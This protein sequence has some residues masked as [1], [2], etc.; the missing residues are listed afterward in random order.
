MSEVFPDAR[1]QGEGRGKGSKE[2]LRGGTDVVPTWT[3]E[4]RGEGERG[5][6]TRMKEEGKGIRGKYGKGMSVMDERVRERGRKGERKGSKDEKDMKG[7]GK[8]DGE[9]TLTP[10]SPPTEKHVT[11]P[12][13]VRVRSNREKEMGPK[14]KKKA[15][16]KAGEI[17]MSA[18]DNPDLGTF[19]GVKV[20][21]IRAKKKAAE[22]GYLRINLSSPPKGLFWGEFNDRRLDTRAVNRLLTRFRGNLDNCSENSAMDLAVRQEWLRPGVEFKATADGVAIADMTEIEFTD[23]GAMAMKKDELWMLGGNHRRKALSLYMAEKAKELEGVK[24]ALATQEEVEEGGGGTTETEAEIK[25]LRTRM[26][27]LEGEIEKGTFWVVRVYDRDAIEKHG[28]LMAKIIFRYLSRNEVKENY[29][30]T[31][32][33]LL[34]EI[35]VELRDAYE[36]DMATAAEK[37]KNAVA[38]ALLRKEEPQ[39]PEPRSEELAIKY[40][41]FVEAVTLKAK[42]EEVKDSRGYRRLC[43]VPSFAHGLVMA[44]RLRRHYTHAEWFRVGALGTMLEAHGGILSDFL[45]ES[46][47]VLER[48]ANP[49]KPPLSMA[50]IDTISDSLREPLGDIDKA[51]ENLEGMKKAFDGRGDPRKWTPELLNEID[52][53]F[54]N[55]YYDNG[56]VCNSLFI[57][58]NEDNICRF[59]RYCSDVD[60]VLTDN[61][62]TA[63]P[64]AREYFAYA[65]IWKVHGRAFPIP[66]G[67]ASVILA[68]HQLL[69][70]HELG[71]TETCYT[72]RTCGVHVHHM[73]TTYGTCPIRGA[74]AVLTLYTW[75][76]QPCTTYRTCPIR[77]ACAVLLYTTCPI[78]GAR[79]VLTLYTWVEQ[80]CTTYRTC[81]IRGARAVLLYTW[82]MSYTWCMCGADT[83]ISWIGAGIYWAP[84][85]NSKQYLIRDPFDAGLNALSRDP[86]IKS[87]FVGG[88]RKEVCRL[89]FANLRTTVAEIDMYL[90]KNGTLRRFVKDL[91]PYRAIA[92]DMGKTPQPGSAKAKTLASTDAF[93]EETDMS[94]LDF[95][96]AYKRVFETMGAKPVTNRLS[97][98]LTS[99]LVAMSGLIWNR[100]SGNSSRD[101]PITA[102]AFAIEAMVL[103]TY[104]QAMLISCPG[105]H[106]LRKHFRDLFLPHSFSVPLSGLQWEFADNIPV[107]ADTNTLVPD[108]DDI[109]RRWDLVHTVYVDG[110]NDPAVKFIQSLQTNK[111]LLSSAPGAQSGTLETLAHFLIT[112]L[113]DI[114]A[115]NKARLAHAS[116]NPEDPDS[117]DLSGIT[118]QPFTKF[119]HALSP[120]YF[121]DFGYEKWGFEYD[122]DTGTLKFPET[123][124]SAP[125]ASAVL[126]P[127][128]DPALTSSPTEPDPGPNPSIPPP[129]PPPLPPPPPF[130]PRQAGSSR[131]NNSPSQAEASFAADPSLDRTPNTQVDHPDI[132]SSSLPPGSSRPHTPPPAQPR[133][134]P[135]SSSP[136]AT[137]DSLA[138]ARPGSPLS[139]TLSGDGRS[140][141]GDGNDPVDS[142]DEPDHRPSSPSI[143]GNTLPPLL[144]IHSTAH[145]TPAL[146][147]FLTEGKKPPY[148]KKKDASPSPAAPASR[149]G[150]ATRNQSTARTA[151]NTRSRGASSLPPDNNDTSP[152]AVHLE[153]VL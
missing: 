56:S 132:P 123:P 89:V 67:T 47:E 33:E 106:L 83:V 96:A 140:E 58:D 12:R 87:K 149:R 77:G 49:E 92:S 73:C 103:P 101:W 141:D 59:E 134:P 136:P 120:Q 119:P 25:G 37:H 125:S 78:R 85:L 76:E 153:D 20:D 80:P 16:G 14:A 127:L 2:K 4:G 26:E 48:L 53:C 44:S 98:H 22:L 135:L 60:K 152:S 54:V 86:L 55:N 50:R 133:P 116:A 110:A 151:P 24:K 46:V 102:C 79:A 91:V 115:K 1:Y 122:P 144:F 39:I 68:V 75:V 113:A 9:K 69:R 5:K 124:V 131:G 42:A 88:L 100:Q 105:A 30:A 23:A 29:K 64:F 71:L 97:S 66:L 38:E 138:G 145:Q 40:P 52:E 142:Q 7:G 148:K 128:P 121:D 6:R 107:I 147:P 31:E 27:M 84:H 3:D 72:W 94:Y 45:V 13:S 43:S 19:I 21:D 74:R 36:R 34:L 118:L 51:V 32:E 41:Q 112:A 95:Y 139:N 108:A 126:P 104:R 114:I 17:K 8:G 90:M 57:P 18:A 62:A 117:F 82:D 99:R 146:P 109:A 150:P 129:P 137:Q 111:F 28:E 130:L 11:P 143:T 70:K 61:H 35:V 10:P 81:P 93:F 65:T 63:P 15:L